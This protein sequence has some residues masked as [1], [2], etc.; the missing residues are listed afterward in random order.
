MLHEISH[1]RQANRS[2]VKRWFN[3][4]DMDLFVWF[5]KNVP[6]RFQLCFNKCSNEQA[7][8]WDFQREFHLYQ[9]DDG[10]T[11]P[12]QY[13]QT[14]LL[15]CACDRNDLATIARNFLAASEKI[16]PG[17]ADFIYARLLEY[18]TVQVK[19]DAAHISHP[20]VQ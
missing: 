6:V 3:S 2:L 7:I 13:K 18:P 17:I 4:R 11:Y 12:D 20:V 8:S 15:V 9:V 14:P 10:E 5:R 19:H 16:D 1:L